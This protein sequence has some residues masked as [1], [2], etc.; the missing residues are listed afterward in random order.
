MTKRK[1]TRRSPPRRAAPKR[2]GGGLGRYIVAVAG[3]AAVGALAAW[4]IL[5]LRSPGTD[6]SAGAAVSATPAGAIQV[7]GV[8]VAEPSVDLG[9]VP[10]DTPVSHEFE[11]R[12][13]G[14]GVA[15]LGQATIEVLEGC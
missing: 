14:T 9:N 11:L 4:A 5:S 10:L 2:S 3:I 12:N 7:A 6:S 13:L 15:M 8:E 1:R